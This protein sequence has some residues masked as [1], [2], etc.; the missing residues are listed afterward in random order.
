[1]A[2]SPASAKLFSPSASSTHGTS[3]S[4]TSLATMSRVPASVP[5]PGPSAS[6]SKEAA[7]SS[8]GFAARREA[9]PVLVSG[10]PSVM[11]SAC[12]EATR[13]WIEAGVATVI[14]PTP[15]RN[16]PRAT[17]TAAPLLPRDPATA[18]RWP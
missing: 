15:E 6:A 1:M 12:C 18:S 7:R 13:D 8:A 10:S 11:T 4:A 16:A 5:R 17:S 9:T 3:L 14:K 2:E